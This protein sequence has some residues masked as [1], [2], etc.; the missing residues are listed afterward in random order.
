MIAMD[1]ELHKNFEEALQTEK[2]QAAEERSA[3]AKERAKLM[4]LV[5]EG[6]THKKK[7]ADL[8][9]HSIN[10]AQKVRETAFHL[11]SHKVSLQNLTQEN[12]TLRRN[13][14]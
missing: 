7:A 6:S 14:S 10:L 1:R 13:S 9:A 5:D 8:E 3:W 4:Q 12:E 11:D 2:R